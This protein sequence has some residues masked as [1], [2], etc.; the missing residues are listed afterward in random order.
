[1]GLKKLGAGCPTGPALPPGRWLGLGGTCAPTLAAH[2]QRM[3]P[4]RRKPD[5]SR[6][7]LSGGFSTSLPD[8][9]QLSLGARRIC[10]V[11]DQRDSQSVDRSLPQNQARPANRFAR[12]RDARRGEQGI[13]GTSARPASTGE[14]VER[15]SAIG[16]DETLSRVARSSNLARPAATRV[17]G[18]SAS[19][20]ST[21]RDSEVAD[22]SR[23]NRVGKDFATNGSEAVMRTGGNK[24][25]LV[26]LGA[27]IRLPMG[28]EP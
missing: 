20:G 15:A 10:D 12:R 17:R 23:A 27:G 6:G 16:P 28:I 22:Q 18:D 2:L 4:I 19:A 1:M 7:H 3:L 21:G 8:D 13:G 11:G 26:F 9:W 25:N 24:R 14:R 5:G